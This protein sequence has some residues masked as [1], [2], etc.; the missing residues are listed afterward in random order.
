MTVSTGTA[1][2]ER[3]ASAGERPA[4]GAPAARPRRWTGGPWLLAGVALLFLVHLATRIWVASE[5]WLYADDL[6]HITQGTTM[7][8]F[9]AEYLFGPDRGGH[10][11]PGAL[12]M[13]GALARVAPLEW[14]PQATALIVL[15]V[16]ASLAV[17]RLLRALMGDRPALLVPLTA[18]LFCSMSLGAFTWWSAAMQSIPL[19][20]G[21]A[22]VVGDAV[23][24]LRTGDRRY[25]V[26]GSVVLALTL[27]FYERAILVPLMALALVA[28]LLHA[29]GT[30]TPVRDAWRRCR[31]LWVG[32]AL[33]L[34]L[35]LCA[36]LAAVPSE[37]AGSA[38]V[39]QLARA[40][41][42]FMTHMLPSLVGGP[43]QWGDV[44]PGTPL[45][46]ASDAVYVLGGIALAALVV[47]TSWRRRGAF[48]LWATAV[49]YA[50]ASGVLVGLGRAGSTYADL[51]PLTYRYY[52]G[53]AVILAIVLAGL[54]ILP[55]R[56]PSPT[57][58]GPRREWREALV[59]VA[60]LLRT[61][62]AV[63][64]GRRVAVP[65]LAVLFVVG[66]T[67]SSIDHVRAWSGDPTKA[68]IT[69]ARASLADAS[70][71]PLLDQGLPQDVLGNYGEYSLASRAFAPLTD[72]PEFADWTDDLR[73][74]DAKGE[75][76]PAQ[77]SDVRQILPGPLTDCGWAVRPGET[78]DIPIGSDVLH[79]IWVVEM[80]YLA[81]H[82][83]IIS[84]QLGVGEPV[85][86]PVEKG[87][88]TVFVRL[89]GDG[90]ELM[91]TSETERLGL[92]ID[93][94][95]VGNIE[96]R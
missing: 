35:W 48:P 27:T 9:S 94:G 64:V 91:V 85:R 45:T 49:A 93:S 39:G 15:Q 81:S 65:V 37:S 78:T 72:R 30:L 43:W 53:E 84:V 25:A 74:L 24:M 29:G 70:P 95:T 1:V 66:S 8:L 88:H 56:V 86:V 20:I 82:D 46:V 28:V 7:D 76:Q 3:P 12:L 13:S 89:W 38:T 69:T 31:A 96:F 52:S 68:Y 23:K 17:L 87:L 36:Y 32:S 55:R 92:C 16:L 21:L 90:G 14:W 54:V 40:V 80:S 61:N 60:R 75:L 59:P 83:G 33:V 71:S 10:L 4:P 58:S 44:P 63:R 67:V 62:R 77:V 5:R 57:E 19:Q 51:L 50:L 22:W 18:Y 11:V 2:E 79:W 41:R 6:M 26:S 42:L 34:A 73:M 47:W